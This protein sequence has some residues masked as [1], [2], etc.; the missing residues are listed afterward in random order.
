MRL[1]RFESRSRNSTVS[2]QIPSENRTMR[3]TKQ[4]GKQGKAQ[5][6]L[7]SSTQS[8]SRGMRCQFPGPLRH[9][10]TKQLAFSVLEARYLTAGSSFTKR[11][12]HL[13]MIVTT[14]LEVEPQIWMVLVMRHAMVCQLSIQ[15][16]WL[17]S[18]SKCFSHLQD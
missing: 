3:I 9:I 18:G 17:G 2:K 14:S 11:I 16:D 13:Y 4:H 7:Q 5:V 1:T 10:R 12:L 6:W 8:L 15:R